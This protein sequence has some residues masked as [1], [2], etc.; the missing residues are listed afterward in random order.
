[1][2]SDGLLDFVTPQEAAHAVFQQLREDNHGEYS[3]HHSFQIGSRELGSALHAWQTHHSANL[4]SVKLW[5]QINAH[6]LTFWWKSWKWWMLGCPAGTMLKFCKVVP[7][8]WVFA[9]SLITTN[10]CSHI[11]DL[12]PQVTWRSDSG[13]RGNSK[14]RIILLPAD[15][16]LHI[17]NHTMGKGANFQTMRTMDVSIFFLHFVWSDTKLLYS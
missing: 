14:R 1:M 8:R 4:T 2:A 6:T 10:C 15:L 3:S 5:I 9:G 17:F 11:Y 13:R 12:P 16:F 7:W